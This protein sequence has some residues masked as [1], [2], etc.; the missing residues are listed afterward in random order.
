MKQFL[1]YLFWPNP[2]DVAYTNPKALALIVLCCALLLGS[3]VLSQWRKKQANPLQKKISR[4]WATAA[5]WFGMRGLLF[6]LSRIEQI[7]YLSMRFL[8]VLWAL[9]VVLFVLVQIRQYRR[10]F[11]KVLP[12]SS[13]ED[14]RAKYLPKRK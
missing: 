3:M 2:G 9:C 1:I 14:P 7:Q 13:T 10:R 12:S 8:W 4:S 5:F 11:Y 6:V